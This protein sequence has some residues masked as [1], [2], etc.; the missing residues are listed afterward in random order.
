MNADE[1]R[2]KTATTVAVCGPEKSVVL[3]FSRAVKTM[4]R[5]RRETYVASALPALV[6]VARGCFVSDHAV[7]VAV[8]TAW[9][10]L[11]GLAGWTPAM[12]RKVDLE[13]RRG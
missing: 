9:A 7:K 8:L 6:A 2:A 12:A 10:A 3:A 1:K 11:A 4:T 5:K 13:L